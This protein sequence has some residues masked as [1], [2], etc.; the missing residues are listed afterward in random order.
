[1][2]AREELTVFAYREVAEFAEDS[3]STLV[4]GLHVLIGQA[5]VEWKVF[6]GVGQGCEPVLL[7][8]FALVTNTEGPI[9]G[10]V[11]TA[12]DALVAR[13]ADIPDHLIPGELSERNAARGR[14]VGPGRME[15]GHVGSQPDTPTRGALADVGVLGLAGVAAELGHR[16]ALVDWL[17]SHGMLLG[18]GPYGP[19]CR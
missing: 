14:Q 15:T 9:A 1:M 6:R 10:S 8:Q 18:F 17:A 5:L 2:G 7:V 4:E 19:G 11:Q 13:K 3:S 12:P 16:A